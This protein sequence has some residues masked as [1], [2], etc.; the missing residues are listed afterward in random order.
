MKKILILLIMTWFILSFLSVITLGDS[1]DADFL[2]L[3]LGESKEATT[4]KLKFLQDK[5]DIKLV[6]Q[7]DNKYQTC[8]LNEDAVFVTSFY[9]GQLIM[10]NFTF[11]NQF[12][13]DEYSKKLKDFILNRIQPRLNKLYGT[14]TKENQF[15]DLKYFSSHKSIWL[16]RWETSNLIIDSVLSKNENLYFVGVSMCDQRLFREMGSEMRKEIKESEEMIEKL[17]KK[18]EELNTKSQN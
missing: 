18:R 13:E 16:S 1:K 17:K 7:S 12:T 10:I 8:F 9:K 14:V 15:P 5:G 2:T 4:E 3:N 6:S 11:P